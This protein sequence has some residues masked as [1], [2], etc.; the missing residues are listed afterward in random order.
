M[1]PVLI[2]LLSVLLVSP[3]NSSADT[4]TIVADEWCPYNCVPGTSKPGYLIEIAETIFKKAGHRVDYKTMNW[5]RSI[6]TTRKGKYTAIASAAKGD[7]PDFIFPEKEQGFS[8]YAFFVKK[9][10]PWKYSGVDSLKKVK[11]GLI[12]DYD[13]GEEVNGYL[14]KNKDTSLAQYAT[15]DDALERNINK[16]KLGRIDV[17]LEDEAVFLLKASEMGKTELFINAGY[18]TG[19]VE[20][21]VIFVA[22]SPSN[23]KSKEYAKILSDGMDELRKSGTLKTILSKYG[24]KDWQTQ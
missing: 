24:L 19:P 10:N 5:S 20:E 15:G 16:A 12:Q 6:E 14:E 18:D 13:Y 7:A 3:V 2:L 1:K 4:I 23:P 9:G 21:N 17:I 8:K 11:L 22:F